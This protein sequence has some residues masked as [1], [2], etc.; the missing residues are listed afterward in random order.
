MFITNKLQSS[1]FDWHGRCV[2]EATEP[3]LLLLVQHSIG[4]TNPD[5]EKTELFL[6]SLNNQQIDE[7]L[8]RILQEMRARDSE[9]LKGDILT[10]SRRLP[11]LARP[12]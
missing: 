9:N 8:S 3:T 4:M 7:L 2:N 5:I 12:E 6:K 1:L 11:R 10:K